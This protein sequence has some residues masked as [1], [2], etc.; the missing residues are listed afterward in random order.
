MAGPWSLA[1]P[2]SSPKQ[3]LTLP[4][5]QCLDYQVEFGGEI[6]LAC[7]RGPGICAYHQQATFR[8]RTQIPSGQMTQLPTDPVAD[9]RTADGAAHDEADVSGLIVIG[10]DEQVSREQRPACP[11]AFPQGRAELAAAPH[12]GG[13][14]QHRCSRQLQV[15]ARG[16]TLTRAR[17]LRRRAARTARPARVRMRSRNPCVF[18]RRRLFGWNVRLLTGTPGTGCRSAGRCD[19]VAACE[20]DAGQAGPQNVTRRH[21]QWSNRQAR[22]AQRRAGPHDPPGGPAGPTRSAGQVGRPTRSARGSAGPHRRQIGRSGSAAWVD[23]PGLRSYWARVRAC[24]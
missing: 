13:G 11:A 17:P 6:R 2:C 20:T 5:K 19:P 7:G 24:R 9:H 23:H 3:R 16:Q 8:K 22:P 18:A 21:R 1:V 10:A 4:P 15:L 12:P 14:G